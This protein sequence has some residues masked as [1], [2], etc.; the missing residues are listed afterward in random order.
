MIATLVSLSII[1]TRFITALMV[2]MIPCQAYMTVG[3]RHWVDGD[4]KRRFIF[5]LDRAD[6]KESLEKRPL[7]FKKLDLMFKQATETVLSG[8]YVYVSDD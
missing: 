3:C 2:D 1:F 6:D 4:D 7:V 8:P 5:V